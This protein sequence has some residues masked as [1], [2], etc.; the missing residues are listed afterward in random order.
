MRGRERAGRPPRRKHPAGKGPVDI[1]TARDPMAWNKRNALRFFLALALAY[2]VGV[3]FLALTQWKQGLAHDESLSYLCAAATEGRYEREIPRL[4]DTLI[5]ASVIQSYYDRPPD[6]RFGLVAHD[7]VHYDGHPPLYYWAL[8]AQYVLFGNGFTGGLWLNVWADLLALLL[9]YRLAREALGGGNAALAACVI[10]YLSPAV[11]QADLEARQYAF[12]ALFATASYLLSWR[13]AERGATTGRLLLFTVVNALGF[14]THYFYGFVLV[15]GLWLIWRRHRFT[16]P[17]WRY[18][19][20]LAASVALFLLAFPQFFQFVALF[21]TRVGSITAMPT[22]WDG[23]RTM[24]Y[25]IVDFF[26]EEPRLRYVYLAMAAAAAAILATRLAKGGLRMDFGIHSAMAFVWLALAWCFAFTLAS[27]FGRLSPTT[28][29]GQRYFSFL[30]PLF[31]IAVVH[32]VRLVLPARPRAP[33]LVGYVLLLGYS[34]TVAARYPTYIPRMVPQSW[35]PVMD[36]GDLLV[37]TDKSRGFLPRTMRGVAPQTPLYILKH[38]LPE[39]M[40]KRQVVFIHPLRKNKETSE[41]F[42]AWMGGQGFEVEETRRIETYAMV[43][44]RR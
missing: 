3:R 17:A 14:L 6:F 8:H 10:W 24:T 43:V 31:A 23:V 32:V 11:V 35:R 30:W 36:G 27:Y 37:V 33:L 19:A 20:S 26:A 21:T 39:V 13:I 42:M 12:W 44:F 25:S 41:R 4:A 22:V 34:F 29:V 16:A 5:T 40:D 18:V 7:L 1:F 9:L 38:V 28:F 2:G 15:P